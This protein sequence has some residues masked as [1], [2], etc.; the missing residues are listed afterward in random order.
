M[1][2]REIS[3]ELSLYFW[4]CTLEEP[5][6]AS[7][8]FQSACP[9]LLVFIGF[10]KSQIHC[11]LMF[12]I[13]WWWCTLYKT[14][15]NTCSI[16]VCLFLNPSFR[17]DYYNVINHTWYQF[18]WF[19]VHVEQTLSSHHW[20]VVLFTQ[21]LLAHWPTGLTVNGVFNTIDIKFWTHAQSIN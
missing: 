16:F 15:M 7:S 6:H 8:R 3:W 13:C 2:S 12:V 5:L 18:I 9:W 21:S 14:E 11:L 19:V 10:F 1:F 4:R 20:A 17:A